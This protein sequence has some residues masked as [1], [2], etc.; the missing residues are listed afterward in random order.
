[1]QKM[2]ARNIYIFQYSDG[3]K[4]HFEID[5]AWNFALYLDVSLSL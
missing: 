3:A 2:E 5:Q 4:V 1:M